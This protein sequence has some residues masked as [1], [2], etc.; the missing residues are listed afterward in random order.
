MPVTPAVGWLREE[1][2]YSLGYRVRACL[3]RKERKTGG[4]ERK[5]GKKDRRDR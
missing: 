5:K 2:W 3:R 4:I 1:D